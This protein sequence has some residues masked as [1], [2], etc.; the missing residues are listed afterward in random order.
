MNRCCKSVT[1]EVFISCLDLKH[2]LLQCRNETWLG[3]IVTNTC[4]YPQRHNNL[5]LGS[6][7]SCNQ[8]FYL[9]K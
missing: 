4:V 2:S 8:K 5:C 9:V 6:Q 1:K 7:D 3:E